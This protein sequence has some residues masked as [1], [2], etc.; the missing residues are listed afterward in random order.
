L[1]LL[2][3]VLLSNLNRLKRYAKQKPVFVLD[4]RLAFDCKQYFDAVHI[5]H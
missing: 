3:G 5:T 4:K 2:I 1:A